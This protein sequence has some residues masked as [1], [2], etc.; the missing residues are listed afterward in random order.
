MGSGGAAGPPRGRGIDLLQAAARAVFPASAV[1]SRAA[2]LSPLH[3]FSD[4]ISISIS[5]S[6]SGRSPSSSAVMLD[7]RAFA[8]G[9]VDDEAVFRA[10]SRDPRSPSALFLPGRISR[11]MVTLCVPGLIGRSD[12][13]DQLVD[14]RL[15]ARIP[16]RVAVQQHLGAPQDEVGR[17]VPADLRAQLRRVHPFLDQHRAG[18]RAEQR[19]AQLV[20]LGAQL[21]D[22]D[23]RGR[24]R[25]RRGRR[26]GVVVIRRRAGGA[27]AG[28]RLR[29][30]IGREQQLTAERWPFA[31]ITPL[32]AGR[33]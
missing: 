12:T 29:G 19:I 4:S 20:V 11:R 8:V 22:V 32:S 2:R 25:R 13:L 26:L 3:H 24:R 21:G 16:D 27:G 33:C 31:S 7:G 1:R 5:G 28:A 30:R 15:L 23:R 10:R 9:H 17:A 6:Y 14:Q 18:A